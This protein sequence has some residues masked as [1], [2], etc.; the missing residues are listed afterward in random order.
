MTYQYSFKDC[1]QRAERI[2]WRVEDLIGGDKA[3]D[4]ARPFLPETFARTEP[5]TFLSAEEKLTLNHI[6]GH[7]Y[8]AM[9]GLV[10]EFILPFVL[11]H[12]RSVINGDDYQARA[13]LEF[14]AEEAK[15]I[16]LFRRFREDFLSGF[17]TR[18]DVIG[19][20]EAIGA[21]VMAQP[22]LS[23]ALLTLQIEWMSQSHYLGS[24]KDDAA[25]D[26]QFKSLLLHHW[27]EE[28]QHAQLDALMTLSIAE[29]L[30]AAEIKAGI[31]G[32]VG[33]GGFF[34]AGLK[35][36][37]AFDL[38]A[39]QRATGRTFSESERELFLTQ[40]LQANRWTYLGSGMTH[41]RFLETVGQLDPA[42]RREIEAL[43]PTFC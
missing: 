29:Q 39:L 24:V 25:L 5:L 4:F 20:P 22:P 2:T 17:G 19:P 31:D 28:H 13:F 26:P 11:D 16:H 18:C 14:A 30:S 15:H 27:M 40:Q 42:K 21:H 8:L 10:E 36:Q 32:Y 35:Q 9:F 43:A 34:D 38:D 23:V 41:P 37:T 7:T 6:R 33:L 3:L 12:A 1:L